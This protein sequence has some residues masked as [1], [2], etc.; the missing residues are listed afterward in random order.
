MSYTAVLDWPIFCQLL[1]MQQT[2]CDFV[3]QCAVEIRRKVKGESVENVG[4]VSTEN[5]S[6]TETTSS[7]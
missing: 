5:L 3:T 4:R 2:Q 6:V 1:P 7:M